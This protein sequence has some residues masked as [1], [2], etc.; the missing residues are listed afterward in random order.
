[1][2]ASSVGVF[3]AFVRFNAVV[4]GFIPRALGGGL[5]GS[6]ARCVERFEGAL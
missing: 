4:A 2:L 3:A 6:V 5:Q 1:M